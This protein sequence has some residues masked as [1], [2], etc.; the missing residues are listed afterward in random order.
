MTILRPFKRLHA[1]PA[2]LLEQRSG[3]LVRLEHSPGARL[4]ARLIAR[5]R[6]QESHAARFEQRAIR[7][8]GRVR[9]HRLVHRRRQHDRRR[10]GE[11]NC[12]EQVA[13]ETGRQR[14]Q[15]VR[16]GGSDDDDIGP[17]RELDVAH[18]G[19]RGRIP[20]VVAHTP[21]GHGLERQ[22]ADELARA[23]RHDDLHFA[24]TIDEAANELG[25]SCTLRFRP[26]RRATLAVPGRVPCLPWGVSGGRAYSRLCARC[27]WLIELFLCLRGLIDAAERAAAARP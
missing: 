13:A 20:E 9:P 6:A 27:H 8:H 21:P 7:L 14:A 10:R 17:A 16:R 22:R 23:T 12:R 19:F 18:R 25:R 24:A 1:Q 26:S 3:D 15:E 2:R 11:A 4:A 5:R